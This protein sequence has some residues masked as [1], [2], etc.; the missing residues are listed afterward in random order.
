MCF[1]V[2]LFRLVHI[3]HV[4][5]FEFTNAISLHTKPNIYIFALCIFYAYCSS[6]V[7]KLYFINTYL[8]RGMSKMCR[9]HQ[10]HHA[11]CKCGGAVEL[12]LICY[13]TGVWH[14]WCGLCDRMRGS[15]WPK[16]NKFTMCLSSKLQNSHNICI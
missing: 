1:F 16:K 13:A 9:Y 15:E 4:C 2:L 11:Y 3:H 14:I 8:Q 12:T 5:A 7:S 10:H 6:S